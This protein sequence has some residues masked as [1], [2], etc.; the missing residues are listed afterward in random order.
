MCCWCMGLRTV[1]D[2]WVLGWHCLMR[3]PLRRRQTL[4]P[5]RD[6]AESPCPG[7]GPSGALSTSFMSTSRQPA[8]LLSTGRLYLFRKSH[9]LL[10]CCRATNVAS[11]AT[12]PSSRVWRMARHIKLLWYVIECEAVCRACLTSGGAMPASAIGWRLWALVGNTYCDPRRWAC[13]ADGTDSMIA[14]RL[15]FFLR[16]CP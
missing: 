12:P 3:L 6:L 14:S 15:G 13:L 8:Q 16:R 7:H 5:P 2:S 9:T 11:R 4:L 10:L 1:G